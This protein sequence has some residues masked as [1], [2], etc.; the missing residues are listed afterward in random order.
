MASR[1][2]LRLQSAT[3]TELHL[4]LRRKHGSPAGST[5]R[6]SSAMPAAVSDALLHWLTALRAP[7]L[8]VA[9]KSALLRLSRPLVMGA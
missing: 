8:D 3:P 4:R 1:L 5:V 9:Q 6:H 2:P 7:T